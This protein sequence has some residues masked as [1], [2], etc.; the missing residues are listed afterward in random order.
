MNDQSPR[1]FTGSLLER[2][3]Q[4]PFASRNAAPAPEGVI[5]KPAPAAPRPRKPILQTRIAEPMVRPVEVPPTPAAPEAPTIRRGAEIEPMREPQARA[6][7]P[8]VEPLDEL[9]LETRV[10]QPEPAV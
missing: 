2:A 9:V 10:L 6:P 4:H 1:R 8:R 5:A 3:A 7:E